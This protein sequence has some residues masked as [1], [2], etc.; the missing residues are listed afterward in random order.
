V[1]EGERASKE[2]KL[3]AGNES[4][5]YSLFATNTLFLVSAYVTYVRYSLK[6]L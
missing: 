1:S 6:R 3:V 2:L 5:Y 4:A